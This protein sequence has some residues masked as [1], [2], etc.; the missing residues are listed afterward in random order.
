MPLSLYISIFL[1]RSLSLCQPRLPTRQF[2][3][4]IAP[5][6]ARIKKSTEEWVKSKAVREQRRRELEAEQCTFYPVLGVGPGGATGGGGGGRNRRSSSAGPRTRANA[7]RAA[8]PAGGS[9]G[10]EEAGPGAAAA[11]A[12]EASASALQQAQEARRKMLRKQ[13]LQLD[14]QETTFEPAVGGGFEGGRPHRRASTGTEGRS[15]SAAATAAAAPAD[16]AKVAMLGGVVSGGGGSAGDMSAAQR[17]E[18]PSGGERKEAIGFKVGHTLMCFARCVSQAFENKLERCMLRCV[19]QTFRQA[20]CGRTDFFIRLFHVAHP[21]ETSAVEVMPRAAIYTPRCPETQGAFAHSS[22]YSIRAAHVSGHGRKSGV[23]YVLV[24]IRQG[25]VLFRFSRV[26]VFLDFF[27][28][29]FWVCRDDDGR[30]WPRGVSTL[31]R[32]RYQMST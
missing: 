5:L 4:P 10:G 1:Y 29:A 14:L 16:A 9:M 22:Q 28:C 17:K 31:L 27:F 18:P 30:C 6:D 2:E 32:P 25:G 20:W 24:L 19:L 11:R 26:E 13:K 23:Q 21:P 12:F 7:S 8:A 3:G 15:A